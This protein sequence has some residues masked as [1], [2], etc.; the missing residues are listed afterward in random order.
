[1]TEECERFKKRSGRQ[2]YQTPKS[3]L[4]FLDTFKAL[5][6]RKLA[7]LEQEAGRVDAGLQKLR[8]GAED[9]EAL[10]L[11]LQ[12]EEEDLIAAEAACG[13]LVQDLQKQSLE[14]ERESAVVA[15]IKEQC[16]VSVLMCASLL[17]CGYVHCAHTLE[18][19]G[20]CL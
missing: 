15:R 4:L 10:R 2:V 20:F 11:V 18:Q 13:K 1:M 14:A 16:E 7:E 8:Q 12:G 5:Y 3:F 6:G 17:V 9:V 19:P